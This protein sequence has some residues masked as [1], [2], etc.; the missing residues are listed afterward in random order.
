[1]EPRENFDIFINEFP[2][3]GVDSLFGRDF[4]IFKPYKK[5]RARNM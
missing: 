3:E 5:K 4:V 1:L 2:G